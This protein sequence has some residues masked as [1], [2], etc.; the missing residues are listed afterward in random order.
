[1]VVRLES[2]PP[3]ESDSFR[4]PDNI[5]ER[6]KIVLKSSSSRVTEWK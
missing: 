6:K 4:I 1:M 3:C 5:Q 2:A